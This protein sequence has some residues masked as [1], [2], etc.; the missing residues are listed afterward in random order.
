MQFN[1]NYMAEIER[2]RKGRKTVP[3]DRVHSAS[4]MA[5]NLPKKKGRK[6]EPYTDFIQLNKQVDLSRMFKSV[7]NWSFLSRTLQPSET[8][9]DSKRSMSTAK[10]LQKAQ[11]STKP[12]KIPLEAH[13]PARTPSIQIPKAQGPHPL[14]SRSSFN[15]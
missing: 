3:I 14:H 9:S 6:C 1:F 8:L 7:S 5:I 10:S 13:K 12:N 15:S 4:K 11:K 2:L